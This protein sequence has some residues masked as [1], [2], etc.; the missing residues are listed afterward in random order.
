[1]PATRPAA[2]DIS[3]ADLAQVKA[4]FKRHGKCKATR[5]AHADGSDTAAAAFPA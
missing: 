3:P 5:Q 4:R 1:L 2:L